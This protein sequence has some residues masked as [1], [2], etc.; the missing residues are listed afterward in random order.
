[1]PDKLTGMRVFVQVV[2]SG[3]F[4]A[5]AEKMNISPQM[6]ARH[7]AALESELGVSLLERTTRRQSLTAT[8]AGY[9]ERCENI[10]NA[11]DDAESSARNEVNQ[12]A[13]TLRINSPVTF[14][15]FSLVPFITC[16]MQRYPDIRVELTLSDTLISPL[17]NG[18]DVVIRIGDTDPLLRLAAKTLTPYRLMLCASPGYLQQHGVPDRPQS[19]SGHQCLGFSPWLAGSHHEWTLTRGQQQ[20]SVEI[21]PRLVINDWSALVQAALQDAG[22]IAGHEAALSGYL[23]RGE[24]IPVLPDYRFP[25]RQ[26]QVLYP[27]RRAKEARIRLLI[28]ELCRWFPATS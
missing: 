2:S 11:I 28:D 8:G 24:L 22:I 25:P 13:G 26:M 5:A 21:S 3:S 23:S 14:G 20:Q 16:F 4:I 10:L 12:P 18:V 17:E 9:L 27:P 19:L 1:M 7:I 6:V 15:R